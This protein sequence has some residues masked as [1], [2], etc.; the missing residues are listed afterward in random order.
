ML[1]PVLKPEQEPGSNLNPNLLF[2]NAQNSFRE[3]LSARVGR[4]AKSSGEIPLKRSASFLYILVHGFNARPE[5][6]G[7]LAQQMRDNLPDSIIH[8]SSCNSSQ[9]GFGNN[10][11]HEGI[12]KAGERLARE[13]RDVAAIYKSAGLR[14][15]SFVGN[16][17]GGMFARY[18]IGLLFDPSRETICG[19]KPVSFVTTVSPHL[20]LHGFVSTVLEGVIANLYR[21]GGAQLY[22][23]RTGEQIFLADADCTDFAPPAANQANASTE[24][25]ATC[26]LMPPSPSGAC[27]ILARDVS[28]LH[29][30]RSP[31]T[32]QDRQAQQVCE[33]GCRIEPVTCQR[34]ADHASSSGD[35]KPLSEFGGGPGARRVPLL[36][37][38][39][40][41][42]PLPFRAGLAAFRHRVAYG[43]TCNDGVRYATATI[44]AGDLPG[45][46]VRAPVSEAFPH[47]VHDSLVPHTRWPPPPRPSTSPA[48]FDRSLGA[49]A[50]VCESPPRGGR[51][52]RA[53]RDRLV[54][55]MRGNLD[56]LGWRR[57]S[58]RF[59]RTVSVGATQTALPGLLGAVGV[60]AHNHLSVA[61]PALNSPGRDTVAHVC[62]VLM[63]HWRAANAAAAAEAAAAEVLTLWLEDD[64]IGGGIGGESAAA[65][66]EA[67]G[68]AGS[69][70][71][72]PPLPCHHL[73]SAGWLCPPAARMPPVDPIAGS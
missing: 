40:T 4:H 23:G 20:G 37:A 21:C 43:N 29:S 6:M 19:L 12:D 28:Q 59:S 15:I 17:M 47:I 36:L 25:A 5:H 3:A 49:N 71:A 30:P 52:A 55:V 65:A 44:A 67:V 9:P 46:S 7:F 32:A 22:G 73:P 61:R 72:P 54:A 66:A 27:P 63:E 11:T 10:P 2:N 50:A 68:S 1:S 57:V 56:G 38:M 42:Q 8:I 41:N 48:P 70:L 34:E 16:S 39:T 35:G 53:G 24:E 14:Y 58:A 62:R 33:S 64:G 51:G 69:Y 26:F 45:W 18:A 60:D 31:E 13:T